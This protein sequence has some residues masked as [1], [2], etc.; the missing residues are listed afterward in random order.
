[1]TD[2]ST[3]WQPATSAA[4]LPPVTAY[5]R[6]DGVQTPVGMRAVQRTRDQSGWL[7]DLVV[8]SHPY[9]AGHTVV[10]AVATE[11]AWWTAQINDTRPATRE[12]E[13]ATVLLEDHRPAYEHPLDIDLRRMT[14]WTD[15][16]TPPSRTPTPSREAGPHIGQRVI[17]LTEGRWVLDHRAISEPYPDASGAT[18]GD[19]Y[20]TVLPTRRWYEARLGLPVRRL[21][22][23]RADQLWLE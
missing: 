14:G 15:T 19:L 13:A 21:A 9:R 2:Q 11:E 12:V 3:N 7:S 16:T 8:A 10:V 22:E 20:V 6:L 18:P 4:P 1:M 23:F 17:A 5:R